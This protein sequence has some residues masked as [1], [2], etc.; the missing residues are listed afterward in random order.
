MPLHAWGDTFFEKIVTLFGRFVRLD[1]RT[2]NKSRLDITRVLV[3]TSSLEAINRVIKV[4]VNDLFFSIRV[5]EEPFSDSY[6]TVFAKETPR[7]LVTSSSSE[8]DSISIIGRNTLDSCGIGEEE[9]FEIQN[10]IDDMILEKWQKEDF[11]ENIG[12]NHGDINGNQLYGDMSANVMEVVGPLVNEV[13]GRIGA[14]SEP[15]LGINSHQ[16]SEGPMASLGPIIQVPWVESVDGPHLPSNG[17]KDQPHA[18]DQSSVST[19]SLGQVGPIEHP[20][21]VA[22]PKSLAQGGVSLGGDRTIHDVSKIDTK[23]TQ[24]KGNGDA[25]LGHTGVDE[26]AILCV[27]SHKETPSGSMHRSKGRHL[28]GRH[29]L[30]PPIL[31]KAPK[32]TKLKKQLAISNRNPVT[33]QDLRSAT[34]SRERTS[35]QAGANT[36]LSVN[37]IGSR[38]GGSRQGSVESVVKEVW[39]FGK[40]LG[41]VSKGEEKEVVNLLRGLEER[42]RG[43]AASNQ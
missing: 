8:E 7:R 13:N 28:G 27:A 14:E 5:L 23:L 11:V 35:S 9:N 2:E 15:I 22:A 6:M 3:Q 16:D 41:M 25:H 40:K 32:V 43:N 18:Q 31:S 30:L 10:F 21:N 4:K 34:M 12:A 20:T 26:E 42:D 24:G 19:P 1:C 29:K 39:D 36:H 17:S 38:N 37:N 33:S